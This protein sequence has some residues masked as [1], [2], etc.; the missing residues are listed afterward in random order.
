MQKEIKKCPKEPKSPC[1]K[2]RMAHQ[3]DNVHWHYYCPRC[4]VEYDL[5]GKTEWED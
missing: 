5:D 1:C 2:I 3:P 4:G